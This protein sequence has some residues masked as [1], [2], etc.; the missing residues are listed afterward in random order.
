MENY[1]KL[2]KLGEG[3]LLLHTFITPQWTIFVFNFFFFVWRPPPHCM[4]PE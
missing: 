4:L 1:Q 3:E 2:E